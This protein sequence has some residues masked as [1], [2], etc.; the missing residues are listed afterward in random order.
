[1]SEVTQ[2]VLGW[3]QGS[4]PFDKPEPCMLAGRWPPDQPSYVL[5]TD[6][7]ASQRQIEELREA[8]KGMNRIYNG[9]PMD[10]FEKAAILG[11]SQAALSPTKE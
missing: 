8:L 3:K 1:M 6:Y 5:A 2:Y 7:D 11:A 9:V 4:G 10:A